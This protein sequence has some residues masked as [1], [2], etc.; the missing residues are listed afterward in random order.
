MG[1]DMRRFEAFKPTAGMGQGFGLGFAVRT[2][3][4]RNPLPGSLGDYYWGGALWHLLL[5][6]PA[7]TTLRGLHDAVARRPPV[8]TASCCADLVYQAIIG[9]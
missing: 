2:E 4:V 7:G 3:Q 5:D 6:R 8:A 1:D 9:N